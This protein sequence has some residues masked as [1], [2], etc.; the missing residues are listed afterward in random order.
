MRKESIMSQQGVPKDVLNVVKKAT[1]KQLSEQS[2]KT[3]ANGVNQKTM[4]DGAELRNL[5]DKVSKMVNIPVSNETSD[6]I[7]KAVKKSG[8]IG[9]LENIM[10]TMMKK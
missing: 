10:K 4:Q 8:N 1:G 2:L 5:I 7:I 6:E 9:Q 3:I